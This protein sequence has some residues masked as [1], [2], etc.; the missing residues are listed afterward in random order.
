MKIQSRKLKLVKTIFHNFLNKSLET[1][2]RFENV[3]K[4]SEE[5]YKTSKL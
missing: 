1:K 5:K 4:E 3:L 2:D